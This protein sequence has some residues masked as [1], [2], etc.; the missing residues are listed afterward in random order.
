MLSE[1]LEVKNYNLASP[2]SVNVLL[3]ELERE[4]SARVVNLPVG[5]TQ[6]IVLDVTGRGFAPELINSVKN[7]IWERLANIYPNIPIDIVG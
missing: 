1:L 2:S 3:N 7:S 4:V 6:R 5:A